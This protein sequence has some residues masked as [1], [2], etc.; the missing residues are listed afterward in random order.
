[1]RPRPTTRSIPP[2]PETRARTIDRKTTDAE[3]TGYDAEVIGTQIE[4]HKAWRRRRVEPA[5]YFPWTPL[6]DEDQ[7]LDGGNGASKYQARFTDRLQ[8]SYLPG[9]SINTEPGAMVQPTN[10]GFDDLYN[11]D[12]EMIWNESAN[13]GKGCPWRP[14]TQKCDYSTDRIRPMPMFDPTQAPQAG[15]KAVEITQFAQIFY[16]GEVGNG[17]NTG[18]MARFLGYITPDPG[19]TDDEDGEGE[20]EGPIV[21]KL[22]LIK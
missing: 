15:R 10:W 20:E 21:K 14:S 1:M 9:D 6:D 16:E 19:G 7:Q 5:W 2:G 4:I 18:F 12:P 13:D 22:R 17:A 11:S 8:G 3:T